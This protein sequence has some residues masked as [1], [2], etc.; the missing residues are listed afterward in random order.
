MIKFQTFNKDLPFIDE[1]NGS[2][3]ENPQRN[4]N[5]WHTLNIPYNIYF[6]NSQNIGSQQYDWF[7]LKDLNFH[8]LETCF[9]QINSMIN[10]FG[11]FNEKLIIDPI[12]SE[13]WTK[14]VLNSVYIHFSNSIN[15]IEA[16]GIA[17]MCA[18]FPSL[19]ELEINYHTEL[20][21][22]ILLSFILKEEQKFGMYLKQI[23][24]LKANPINFNRQECWIRIDKLNQK[25]GVCV[26]DK[27]IPCKAIHIDIIWEFR[28]FE[29]LDSSLD[30]N[31]QFLIVKN[32][33]V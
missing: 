10:I 22:S 32:K 25:F 29:Y 20:D 8:T 19:Q 13:S 23:K 16:K 24:F 2:M 12:N 28:W 21:R 11:D 27:I 9:P 33:S 17:W 15:E 4:V 18:R 3:L 31:Q 5:R 26:D 30:K 14:L 1:I 6:T 7:K